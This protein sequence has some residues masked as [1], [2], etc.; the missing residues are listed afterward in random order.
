MRPNGWRLR[1]GFFVEK[2]NQ[3]D[4]SRQMIRDRMMD[5]RRRGDVVRR[6]PL[7]FERSIVATG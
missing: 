4:Y 7:R 1:F 3:F 2:A 6:E 5:F